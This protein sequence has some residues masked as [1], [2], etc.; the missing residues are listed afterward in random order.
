MQRRYNNILLIIKQF[1][2]KT[3]FIFIALYSVVFS[4]QT[5]DVD[6]ISDSSNGMISFAVGDLKQA[7]SLRSHKVTESP[8]SQLAMTTGDVHIVL[9]TLE[10]SGVIKVLQETGK[11]VPTVLKAEGYSILLTTKQNSKTFWIIGAD[12]KGVMY[13]GL[14]ITEIITL[15][16]LASITEKIQNPHLE[17]RG[18]KLNIPLDA[19]TPSYADAGN[20][21]Q[22][23]IKEMWS[24]DFWT[25]QLDLLARHRYNVITLWNLHPFPSM[26]KV[27]EYPDV[28]LDDVKR[29][30]INWKAWYINYKNPGTNMYNKQAMDSLETIKEIRIDDKIKFWQDVMQYA[31]D[32]G[33]EF[34][35]ITWNVFVSSAGEHYGITADMENKTT[36]DYFRKSVRSLFETYPLLGGIG[37]TAGEGMHGATV[38]EKEDWL[39]KTYGAG[40]MD[41]K[42]ADS[43]D[44]V[45]RFIHRYWWSEIPEI[46]NHF[47]GF[48]DDVIFDFSF[49]YSEA[50][51]YSETNPQFANNALESLPEGMQFWWNLRNDDIFNFRWA[52]ADYVREFI[53]NFPGNGQ[54]I[55]FHMGSDGYAWGREFS[56][57]EAN[58]PREL[59]IE[60]HWLSYL[61]WGRMG[62]NN[63]ISNKHIEK[64]VQNKYPGVNAEL[65]L[66]VWQEA[67]K[68]IPTVNKGH[69]HSWDYQWSVEYCKAKEGFHYINE[70]EWGAGNSSVAK[71]LKE[72]ASFVLTHINKIWGSLDKDLRLLAGDIEA[73]AH[74]GN[75]YA[76]KF[77]AADNKSTDSLQAFKHLQIAAEHWRKYA[78]ISSSQY[79]PQLLGRAGWMDWREIYDEV[80]KDPTILKNQEVVVVVP[81]TKGGVVLEAENQLKS[82][83]SATI[84][85]GGTA[86]TYVSFSDVVPEISWNYNVKEEGRYI[87]EFRYSLSSGEFTLP[88][89]INGKPADSLGVWKTGNEGSWAWD[90][91]IV[92]LDKGNNTIKLKGLNSSISVDHVNILEVN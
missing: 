71:T 16:G 86:I 51:L 26:V 50:R 44:R 79:K 28:A 5:V 48:D 63:E 6:I 20:S 32:R 14:E 66:K 68:I 19:R 4:A 88:L 52:D 57:T 74:L 85:N 23:N 21:A 39:W 31:H 75:Y 80:L 72:Y 41:A 83:V 78:S 69:Y 33:I 87:L 35:I 59:E 36:I 84:K 92:Q 1:S 91:V 11:T 43:T 12:A 10:D 24:W 49:K 3:I 2:V 60:K 62:Y 7:L 55:G 17:K 89:I 73:M 54:T 40:L 82:K 13:G 42:S 25:Q 37:V 61:L 65:L 45:Y 38:A 77:M 29:S 47:K 76:E 34:H 56:S 58:A 15:D 27:P 64:L 81:P 53:N 9:A 90:R 30:T 67:S 70:K 22:E 8:L 18:I 46:L